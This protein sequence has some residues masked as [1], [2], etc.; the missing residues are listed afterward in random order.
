MFKNTYKEYTVWELYNSF[1]DMFYAYPKNFTAVYDVEDVS[2]KLISLDML[3]IEMNNT[4]QVTLFPTANDYQN[5][6]N[7]TVLTEYT[8][9]LLDY[10]NWLLNIIRPLALWNVVKF[11]WQYN[12][13]NIRQFINLLNKSLRTLNRYFPITWV[14]TYSFSWELEYIDLTSIP[15]ETI[16][17]VYQNLADVKW[18]NF[19]RRDKYL[20]ITE[21]SWNE[22]GNSYN[23]PTDYWIDYRSKS[24]NSVESPLYIEGV[25]TPQQIQWTDDWDKV[26]W[27]TFKYPSVWYDWLL[28][29]MWIDMYRIR[30]RYSAEINMYTLRLNEQWITMN[31]QNLSFELSQIT[32]DMSIAK[33]RYR[34]ST[35]PQDM[36]KTST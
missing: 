33:S 9:F 3:P 17:D 1:R 18:I 28:V 36:N 31:M 23:D 10:D 22:Q 15:F 34:A 12:I 7:G 29:S 6:I 16:T 4:H 11:I 2:K 27:M 5:N 24:T 32:R 35:Y 20:I 14:E 26:K 19:I 13:I 8:D 25:Y 21:R 30:L